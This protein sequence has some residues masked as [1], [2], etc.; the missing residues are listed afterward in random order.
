MVAIEQVELFDSVSNAR[1]LEDAERHYRAVVPM[2]WGDHPQDEASLNALD[3]LNHV[4]ERAA[5]IQKQERELSALIDD[6]WSVISQCP[7]DHG[8]SGVKLILYKDTRKH[9]RVRDP[10][11]AIFD[12]DEFESIE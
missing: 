1:A 8:M 5:F 11:E 12:T 3:H 7:M 10:L 2:F 6:G 4:K 9:H